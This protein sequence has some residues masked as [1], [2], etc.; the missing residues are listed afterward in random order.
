[1][2]RTAARPPHHSANTQAQPVRLFRFAVPTMLLP[3]R[4]HE[5][6]EQGPNV[7]LAY[8]PPVQ[9]D[10]EVGTAA[11]AGGVHVL[12]AAPTIAAAVVGTAAAAGGAHTGLDGTFIVFLSQESD[13]TSQSFGITAVPRRGQSFEV[14]SPEI[15]SV[16]ALKLRKFGA[17]SDNV[18]V[19]IHSNATNKPSNITIETASVVSSATLTG[20]GA[21]YDFTL[22]SPLALSAGTQYWIVV[23]RSGAVDD[24]NAYAFHRSAANIEAA[25]L[26]SAD[27]GTW[28]AGTSAYDHCFRLS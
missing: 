3:V 10:S 19:E 12:T 17:P 7:R 21:W 25:W 15:L 4:H 23:G 6:L 14:A 2:T 28:S 9:G 16:V 1:M 22:T 8:R 5:I 20:S 24:V 11:A 13:A 26:A 27:T 18:T